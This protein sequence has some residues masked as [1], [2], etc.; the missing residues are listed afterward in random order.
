MTINELYEELS[1]FAGTDLGHREIKV[2]VDSPDS[3]YDAEI[4]GL[5][6]L[7]NGNIVINAALDD[8]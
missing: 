5:T 1:G 6:E 3:F 2:L 4:L 8:R 7:D